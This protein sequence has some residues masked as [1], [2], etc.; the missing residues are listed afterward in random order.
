MHFRYS[1]WTPESMTDEQRL[2]QLM[3][4]FSNLLVRTNGD[5]EEAIEWLKQLA[6]E[7]GIFDESLSLEDLLAKLKEMGVIEEVDR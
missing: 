4:L 3:S 7:Y 1:K 6:Q 5:V 2:E